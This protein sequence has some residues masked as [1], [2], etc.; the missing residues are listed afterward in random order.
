MASK[1]P[2]V[3]PR[4]KA[5]ASRAGAKLEAMRLY[6]EKALKRLAWLMENADSEQAQVAAAK[7]L[8]DRVAGRPFA[9]AEGEAR[10]GLDDVVAR[11]RALRAG[12]RDG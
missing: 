7:E 10:P 3:K 2:A 1:A 4:G 8:L 5:K 12:R 6:G 9:A 11:L